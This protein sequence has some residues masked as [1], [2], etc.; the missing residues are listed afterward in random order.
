MDF[1]QVIIDK[2][3]Q[4]KEELIAISD[5]MQRNPEIGH[6]E[7]KASWIL[8]NYLEYE[9]FIV[10]R[11][12]AGMETAFKAVVQGKKKGPVVALLAELDA[13][14]EVGHGCGHNI[15]ATSAVGAAISL[16]KIMSEIDGSLVVFGCPSEEAPLL[17]S[18]ESAPHRPGGKVIMIEKG[19]FDE[20]DFALMIHPAREGYSYM[21]RTRSVA[22][23]GLQ[24]SLI[25]GLPDYEGSIKIASERLTSY[26]ED[27]RKSLNGRDIWIE[28]VDEGNDWIETR[29]R[30][31]G[32][33]VP[34][35]FALSEGALIGLDKIAKETGVLMY[36]RYFM[37]P[38]ADMIW[39]INMSEAYKKNLFLLG[40]E[41]KEIVDRANRGDEGNVSHVVPAI[42]T[43]IKS[44]GSNVPGHSKEFAEA[45]VTD[46]GHE[47]L[48]LGAKSLAMT[49][50]DL[51]L[52][53]KLVDEIITEFSS[54]NPARSSQIMK[55]IQKYRD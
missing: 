17:P 4:R 29:V 12:I 8:S 9:G 37:N 23:T 46:Y 32:P 35:V 18:S 15:I 52:D 3:D 1:K 16:K 47:G 24:I 30:T 36:Y 38:Y 22:S 53:K 14:P 44:T 34:S 27:Y 49:T 26:I 48:M 13:L 43:W 21:R 6:R 40:D 11:N 39:N 54:I 55:R 25:N 33:N 42:C 45:S 31:T 7:Y 2:I 50:L 20:I 28:R 51:F 19:C 5:W 10:D 41:P